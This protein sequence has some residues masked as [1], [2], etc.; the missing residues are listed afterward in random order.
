MTW[1]E[2]LLLLHLRYE[3]ILNSALF[4]QAVDYEYFELFQPYS[5]LHLIQISII[6]E[7]WYT[8]IATCSLF[9]DLQS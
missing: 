6:R 9:I 4:S 5:V 3:S 7:A 1:M 8:S 2:I